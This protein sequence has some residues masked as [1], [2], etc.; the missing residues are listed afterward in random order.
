MEFDGSWKV[1]QDETSNFV[2]QRE[3]SQY[4]E[5]RMIN[6]QLWENYAFEARVKILQLSTVEYGTFDMLFRTQRSDCY[7]Q[8][9][10]CYKWNVNTEYLVFVREPGWIEFQMTKFSLPLNT[11][12]T[13]RVEMLGNQMRG[14]VNSEQFFETNDSQPLLK[15][16]AGF[17]VNDN[18]N[19]WF[20]DVQVVELIPSN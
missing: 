2:L 4:A 9:F 5:A 17:S 12:F 13:L 18:A 15:G 16:G 19:V 20:D 10:P 11:W 14:Y 6:S 7:K 1:V 3:G 8:E